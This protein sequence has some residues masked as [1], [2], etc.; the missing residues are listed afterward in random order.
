[1]DPGTTILLSPQLPQSQAI[2]GRQYSE[3]VGSKG[4]LRLSTRKG[5]VPIRLQ[6]C[7]IAWDPL[8]IL[9][10]YCLPWEEH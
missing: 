4:G 5:Q 10:T 8:L 6:L 7:P 2:P 9:V 1:M 3:V